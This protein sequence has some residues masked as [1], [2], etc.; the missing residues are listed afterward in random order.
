MDKKNSFQFN[1]IAP[2]YGLFYNAYRFKLKT[3]RKIELVDK[4]Q[5]NYIKFVELTVR[6]RNLIHANIFESY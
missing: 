5:T 6:K 1:M 4:G 2:I 3:I